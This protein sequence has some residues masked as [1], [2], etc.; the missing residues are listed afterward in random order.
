MFGS[1]PSFGFGS[2]CVGV[3]VGALAGCVDEGEPPDDLGSAE[4]EIVGGTTTAVR[5]EI[6]RYFNAG[7]GACTATLIAPRVVL[8]A[9]HC[10]SPA[11]TA[12]APLAGA[13]FRFT[14]A[15]GTQRDYTVDRLRSFASRR[16][17]YTSTSLFT[18]DVAILHLTAAVPASQATPAPLALQ[19]PYGGEQATLFG[20]G[21]T[22][23]T[24][25]SGGGGKQAFEFNVF[26]ATTALCWGDSG[27][28]DM[29]GRTGDGGEIWGVNSDFNMTGPTDGWTDIFAAVPFY[30]KEIEAQLRAWDGA[31]EVGID[32]PGM[33]YTTVS[34]ASAAACRSTCEAD[35]RCA[36]FTW[37]PWGTCYLKD[38]VPEPYRA[39]YDG[40]TSG[41]PTRYE[42]GQNRAGADYAGFYLP[43]ARP[44]LCA[45]A[46]G[47]DQQCQSWTYAYPPG[48]SASACWLKTAV[49]ARSAC[50]YCTSGVVKREAE[51]GYNRGG[52]DYAVS[53]VSSAAQCADTC[54]QD[55]RCEAYTHTS[56]GYC[57][58]KDAAPWAARLAGATSG[59][60][61]GLELDVNRWGGDYRGF[62]TYD[63]SPRTCQAA[64][65]RE[66]QC[67]AWT[68]APAANG[69]PYASCWLKSS[70]PYGYGG[71]TGLIS[72]VKGLEM[73]P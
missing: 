12:T 66:S 21:C 13:F 60:R 30:R 63:L 6:G 3:L 38:G 49:P 40:M 39:W 68:Y 11:Y 72:G 48:W 53:Y 58:L 14:D 9:A 42:V 64:C 70:V 50:S 62:G 47:R 36:A 8:T 28:P 57:W 54:A 7:G 52:Y 4:E 69:T 41:V 59:V 46:C 33:D 17:E 61:G 32:R 22:D 20:F 71:Q 19:E 55:Q 73:L 26:S 15:G 34:S 37:G 5:P 1:R 10:L 67:Q 16:Y 44:E 45:A 18:T 2:L 51:V 56:N 43:E 25:E 27:G 31:N 23:R 65:A 24:P 29:Y 35:G